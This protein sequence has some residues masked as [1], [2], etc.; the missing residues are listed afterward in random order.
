MKYDYVW[1]FSEGLARVELKDKCGY[2]NVSGQE[3]IQLKYDKVKPF[4]EGLAHVE[5]NGKWGYIDKKGTD[6]WED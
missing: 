3:V 2:I 6:Y 4:K 5:L 1:D